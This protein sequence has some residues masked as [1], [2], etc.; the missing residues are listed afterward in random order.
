M[1]LYVCHPHTGIYRFG[2][3]SQF[4]QTP[5]HPYAPPPVFLL[6]IFVL[7]LH[8][9]IFP[10]SQMSSSESSSLGKRTQERPPSSREFAT[11]PR[12]QRSTASIHRE[13]ATRYVLVTIGSFN[14]IV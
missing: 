2:L 12:V 1:G 13:L 4:R 6:A 3:S 9:R 14:L 7:W 8:N 5:S 11:P 10:M